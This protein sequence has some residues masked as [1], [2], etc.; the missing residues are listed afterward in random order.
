MTLLRRLERPE[1]F[2]GGYVS[3]GN[4][5]GV[6]RG[7]QEIAEHLAARSRREGVPAVIL[8]F[9]PHPLALLRPGHVPPALTTLEH[10][11]ELLERAGAT[12]VIAYPTDKA[13]LGL[14]PAEFV[15][16]ILVGQLAAKGI[17]EGP[18]FCFGKDRAGDIDTLRQLCRDRN[19]LLEVAEPVGGARTMVSSSTI[20]TRVAAGKIAEAA[21]LLGHP[22]RL[23]GDVVAGARRGQ[24]IGFPTANLA[25]IATLV[26]A[27]GVYAGVARVGER[28]LAAAINIGPNPTF[29]EQARKV[30]V[31]LIEFSGDLYG[32]PLAVDLLDR[33]R[34]VRKFSGREELVAQIGK[35]VAAARK[36][37]ERRE[38]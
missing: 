22:Y 5:D 38:A 8:T 24:E 21:E 31:H 9:D 11:A 23:A 29:H 34:D 13:L 2:R 17:I 7:H 19:I 4:F 27:D 28:E 18:N 35:D 33:V 32:R 15:D 30:E 3:I 14:T 36:I 26:P 16:A 1:L 20:R 25:G 10:K 6:H 12:C 37:A